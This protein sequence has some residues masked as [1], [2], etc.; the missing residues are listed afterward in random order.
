V[1]EPERSPDAAAACPDDVPLYSSRIASI[2]LALLRRRYPEVDAD[3]LL[4]YAGMERAQVEDAGHWFTQRQVNRFQ[5]R[6]RQLTGNPGIAREAGLFNASPE[7]L[8]G[9]KRY[10]LGLGGP[11]R[12]YA[13]IG[14]FVNKFTRS[15]TYV[16][17]RVG[18]HTVEVVVTPRPGVHEERFQC[19]NRL[20][21]MESIARLF[22][23]RPPRIEHPECLFAGGRQCRYLITWESSPAERLRRARTLGLPVLALALVALALLAPPWPAL[24][25]A[26]PLAAAVALGVEARIARIERDGLAAAVRNLEE[27]SDELIEQHR[28]SYENALMIN[29]IGQ[30]LN[31]KSDLESILASVVEILERRLDFDRGLV[32]LA[33]PGKTRLL[34]KGGYGYDRALLDDLV[35][36]EGFRLDPAASRGIF[37]TCFWERR[38]FLVD[39]V[40]AV[41]GSLSAR[42]RALM[43]SLGVRSFIACPIAYE[44][45]PLG[46]LAVD[47][48]RSKRPLLER[49]WNLLMGIAPQIAVCISNVRL[50]E[51]RLR[52]FQ[53]ILEVL[54]ATTE[55]RDPITAGHSRKVTEYAVGIARRLGFP[56]DHVEMIR[57]AAS[58]HDYGKIGIYDTILRK[59]GRLT[60]EEH[61]EVKVHVSKTREILSRVNFEG[62]YTAV[63]DIAGSHHEKL[64]G[65]GY[66]RGLAGEAIPLGAR[67][68]AVADVFEALTSKRHYRDPMPLEEAFD[69]LV[70]DCGSHF[71]PRCVEA[72]IE[73]F[74][75]EVA[76]LDCTFAEASLRLAGGRGASRDRVLN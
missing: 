76:P 63:P 26:L 32:L 19:E 49:D 61:E 22:Q 1:A 75:E 27:T 2:Y 4:S 58:L 5:E 8:G 35:A 52:Q 42:S 65:S 39:D 59:P 56:A 74:R 66:P 50:N 16:S 3:D 51:S 57:V 70:A 23:R 25:V 30:S 60:A 55:A 10:I 12:A 9:I 64:D 40:E 29:E 41:R 18:S 47:N 11:A 37:T 43:A 44:D 46:V 34:L 17:R 68:L 62:V 69:Q 14:H 28:R 15:S 67:I 54:V 20:G 72:L 36:S 45:E 73:H 31:R 38:S 6:L 13:L 33:D 53:S 71:D 24:A 48:V 7:V 21:H